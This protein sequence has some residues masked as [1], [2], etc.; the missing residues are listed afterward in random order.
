MLLLHA[1]EK[2]LRENQVVSTAPSCA[3]RGAPIPLEGSRQLI[4]QTRE[5]SADLLPD[6]TREEFREVEQAVLKNA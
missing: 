3:K 6:V 5:N 1:A 4:K 2:E